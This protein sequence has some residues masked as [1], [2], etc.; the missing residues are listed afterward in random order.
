VLK[1]HGV[2]VLGTSVQTIMNCEDRELFV[3]RLNE[4]G[5]KVPRNISK[6][7]KRSNT[8]WSVTGTTTA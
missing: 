8:K 1:K 5:I 2:Q 3:N 4:I 6:A 7:G